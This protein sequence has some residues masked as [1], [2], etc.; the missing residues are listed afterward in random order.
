LLFSLLN[1]LI[2]TNANRHADITAI[3][4][5]TLPGLRELRSTLSQER[6]YQQRIS[7]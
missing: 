4:K 7:A 3:W 1:H 2:A 6:R 5:K